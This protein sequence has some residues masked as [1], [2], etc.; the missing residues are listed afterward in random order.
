MP[1]HDPQMLKGVL[2]L[3]LLSVL[4]TGD[5]YGYGLVDP[6]ARPSA[7]TASPRAPSTRRSPGLEASGAPRVP[8]RAQRRGP[9]SQ[10]LRPHRAWDAPSSRPASTAWDDLVRS[11]QT[12]TAAS[13]TQGRQHEPH[14]P[15]P[16]RDR[17]PQVR[18]LARDARRAR[19]GG[20]ATCVAAAAAPTSLEARAACGHHS[21]TL[22][23]RL[24]QG[25]RRMPPPTA[26]RRVPGG[27][28]EPSG[29]RWYSRWSCSACMFTRHRLHGRGGGQRR[30][31]ADRPERCRLPLVRRT[32]TRPRVE[33]AAQSTRAGSPGASAI[34]LRSGCRCSS[35]CL[36]AQ[37]WR[38]L[39][40]SIRRFPLAASQK[41]R[42]ERE[43]GR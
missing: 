21:R 20:G 24:V 28:K 25:S 31:R 1:A 19:T 33:P 30:E 16:D 3:L 43:P 35:S 7:S 13:L 36:V 18:L 8:A 9:G 4:S 12:A 17:D 2:G 10:V 38:L 22:R 23:H 34:V 15:L 27:P 40:R 26:T 29:L 6:A 32:T 39:R 41:R 37:P 11:V 5:N 42:I 14:R